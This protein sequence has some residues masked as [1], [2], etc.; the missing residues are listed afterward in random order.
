LNLVLDAGCLRLDDEKR[1]VGFEGDV[2][3]FI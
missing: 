2:E 3:P 1:V